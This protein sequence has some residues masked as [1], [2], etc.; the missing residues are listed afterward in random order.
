MI[1]FIIK[2][3]I[4]NDFQSLLFDSNFDKSLYDAGVN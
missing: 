2:S 3:Y 4:D 1:I